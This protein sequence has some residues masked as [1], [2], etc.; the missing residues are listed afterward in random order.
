[1]DLQAID[2][3]VR[4]HM[5][6][7]EEGKFFWGCEGPFNRKCDDMTEGRKINRLRSLERRIEKA[8]GKKRKFLKREYDLTRRSL[9]KM[10]WVSSHAIGI[11]YP[12]P[13]RLDGTY[14]RPTR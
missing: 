12:G 1:M 4:L 9:G 13:F 10:V 6:E 8:S 11:P 2:R 3:G 5:G 14:K 7:R